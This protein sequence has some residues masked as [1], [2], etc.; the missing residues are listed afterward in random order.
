[1][2]TVLYGSC[3]SRSFRLIEEGRARNRPSS[4]CRRGRDNFAS[5]MAEQSSGDDVTGL[6]ASWAAGDQDA[7]NELTTH[8]YERLRS[9]SATFLRHERADH[10]LQTTALMHE[11]FL[12]LVKQQRVVYQ[13]R[14]QFFANV[15]LMMRRI[16]VDHARA[17]RV[18][19]RG[20]GAER[21]DDEILDQMAG[22]EPPPDL[23][24]LDD[25]LQELEG[26]QPELARIVQFKF[27]VGLTLTEISSIT[28][29]G[30]ATIQRRWRL[31]RAWL[32]QRLDVATVMG[33]EEQNA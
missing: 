33:G 25:A 30:S 10:T 3:R 2:L 29:Q 8:V 26:E 27:F 32:R 13:N 6:L 14:E 9:L 21:V 24:Q 20:S 7:L 28:G 11:A 16:L 19:K 5:L 4:G 12:R 22:P 1:M 15:A 31:A 23:V 17:R 18:K